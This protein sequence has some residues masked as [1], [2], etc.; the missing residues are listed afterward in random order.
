MPTTTEYAKFYTDNGWKIFPIKSRDKLPLFPAAHQKD[1]PLRSTCKGECGKLGHGLNDATKEINLF[2]GWLEM[3]PDMNIGLVAGKESGFFVIDID[4]GHGGMESLQEIESKYGALPA[5]PR[6]KTGGGG[7]HILF[8]YPSGVDVRNVQTSGKIGKGIDVRGQGGY[9]VAPPSVHPSGVQYAWDKDFAPSKTPLADAPK[10]LLDLLTSAPVEQVAVL[11]EDKSAI[12]NGGRNNTLTSL[13]GAMRRKGMSDA[14]I[15]QALLIENKQ[16]CIPP[17]ADHEVKMIADSVTR[18]TPAVSYEQNRDR[19]Q[20]EWSFCKAIFEFPDNAKDFIEVLPMMFQDHTLAEFWEAIQDNQEVTDAAIQ[21]KILTEL[22]RYKDYDVSRL[23]GYANSIQR[24]SYLA[25]VAKKGEALAYQAKNAND[26]GIEKAV[27]EITKIPSQSK[28]VVISIGDTA[29]KVEQMIRE[30]AAN[31]TDVWGIPYAWSYLSTLTGGKQKGEVTLFSAEPKIGKSWWNLQDALQTAIK[32]T[33]V[34]YWCGEMKRTQ[35]MM[36]FYQLLGVNG[37]RMKNGQMTSDDW[38]ALT[39]AKALIMNSPLFID[40]SPL[41]LHELRPM[42]AKQ[43]AEHGIEQVVIDY[44]MKILA[45]GRDEIEQ[46]SNISKEVKS[47]ALDLD[48][49]VTLI[50]SVNKMGM[51]SK[52][53]SASKSNVRG[54]GQQ[55]HDADVIYIMTKFNEKYGIDYGIMP[56]EYDKTISLHIAAG[57]ELDHQIEGGFIPYMRE[58]F[59]PKFKELKRTK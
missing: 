25:E 6:A 16:K 46:T 49:A 36:R 24:F 30:R 3:Y 7:V 43:K 29:D 44:A 40:D 48:L 58:G 33:P 22:E 55:I 10:W 11:Q 26:A 56:N 1:D 51:D 47:I 17:L 9:I 14:A 2:N 42:L 57:R 52:T 18:Y 53:E 59:T 19:L 28:H 31:P 23:D 54:S 15:Y 27:N 39:D 5:T 50:T 37:R 32:D 20:T 41:M 12:P 21:A 45:P 35:L 34:F 38:D 13:A 4:A 8:K